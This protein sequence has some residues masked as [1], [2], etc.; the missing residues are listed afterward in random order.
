MK[1]T[2]DYDQGC[3]CPTEY[4][5]WDMH[6][7]SSRHCNF[8][9]PDELFPANIGLRR[10]LKCGT[11]FILSYFEHGYCMWSLSG[12]GPQCRWDTAQFAGILIY[13]DPVKYLP[14]GWHKR[15]EM[16]RSFLEEYTKWCNGEIYCYSIEDDDE[17]VD[18]C[19][20][21]IG[22]EWFIENLKDEHPELFAEDAVLE[23]SGDASFIFEYA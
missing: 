7:F 5:A 3:E 1:L 13:K 23:T 10:K 4:G 21:F 6:S 17:V 9:N 2:I 11:A 14:K 18:S 22:A 12:E 8:K 15:A 19:G 16:A 20:G